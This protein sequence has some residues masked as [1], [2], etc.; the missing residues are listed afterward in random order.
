MA[1]EIIYLWAARMIFSSLEFLKTI[2]FKDVYIHS[3]ILT[4]EGKRMSK[5]LVTGID[6]LELIE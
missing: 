3:T 2:P 5:S 6:P 4:L 1:R